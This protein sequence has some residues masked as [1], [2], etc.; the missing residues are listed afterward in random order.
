M[1]KMLIRVASLSFLLVT[2]ALAGAPGETFNPI[3]SK[4]QL[5]THGSG[6]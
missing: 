5:M 3:Q 6:G 2:V 1:K 4:V